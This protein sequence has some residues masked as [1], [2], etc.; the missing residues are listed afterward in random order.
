MVQSGSGL[1]GHLYFSFVPGIEAQSIS[2]DTMTI[3]ISDR[4]FSTAFSDENANA[5]SPV[6]IPGQLTIQSGSCCLGDRGNINGSPD[7][8][9]D[10]SDLVYLVD[11]MFRDGPDLICKAEANVDGSIDEEVDISDLVYLVDF[12]FRSGPALPSCP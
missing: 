3:T 5:F 12:M 8:A 10:I 1:L 6:V 11:F 4:E 9:Q 7:D 2:V